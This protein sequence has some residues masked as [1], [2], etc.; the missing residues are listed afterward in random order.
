MLLF[1]L[2]LLRGTDEMPERM[3]ITVTGSDRPVT[4][5]Q[6][7]SPSESFA[8]SDLESEVLHNAPITGA[9]DLAATQP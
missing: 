6:G 3:L 4:R 8:F 7:L 2:R 1:A 9:L 5:G